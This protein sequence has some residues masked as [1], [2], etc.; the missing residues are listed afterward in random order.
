MKKHKTNEIKLVICSIHRRTILDDSN[1]EGG[2]H[3]Q[4]LIG[5]KRLKQHF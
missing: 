4:G 1:S 2:Q 3:K 5:L